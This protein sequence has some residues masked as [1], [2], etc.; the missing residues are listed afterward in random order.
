MLDDY[1][2]PKLDP[3]RAI[4]ELDAS[5]PIGRVAKPD[6]I[7]GAVAFLASGE[8]RYMCGALLEI[9]GGKPAG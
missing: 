2:E 7:A 8:A 4:A 6:D 5:V 3:E 9:N 1:E